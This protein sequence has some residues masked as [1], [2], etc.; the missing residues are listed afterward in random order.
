VPKIRL[1]VNHFGL[2]PSSYR[3]SWWSFE[4]YGQSG[5]TP[6]R[7]CFESGQEGYFSG[8]IGSSGRQ[9]GSEGRETFDG[10]RWLH[11]LGDFRNANTKR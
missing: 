5:A 7:C 2:Q 10:V 9:S 6:L 11:C 8:N 1:T 3:G 4:G